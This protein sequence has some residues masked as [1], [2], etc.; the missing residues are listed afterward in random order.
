[1]VSALT[2]VEGSVGLT[3]CGCVAAL[4][5]IPAPQHCCPDGTLKGD[6]A[7]SNFHVAQHKLVQDPSIHLS[8]L[9]RVLPMAQEGQ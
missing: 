6:M 7:E 4:F 5:Y 3:A 2:C 9:P 8:K 1:M